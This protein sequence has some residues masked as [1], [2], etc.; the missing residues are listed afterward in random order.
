MPKSFRVY[1]N[2]LE[3]DYSIHT[4]PACSKCGYLNPDNAKFCQECGAPLASPLV[5]EQVSETPLAVETPAGRG[6]T[7]VEKGVLAGAILVIVLIIGV[8]ASLSYS[9]S[10]TAPAPPPPPP[11]P[12]YQPSWH[13]IASLSGGDTG[14]DGLLTPRFHIQNAEFRI[15]WN[16]ASYSGYENNCGFWFFV[17]NNSARVYQLLPQFCQQGRSMGN[18]MTEVSSGTGTFFLEIDAAWVNWDVSIMDYY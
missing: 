15:L 10:R 8:F 16:Y 4:L 12:A 9:P 14:I 2:K 17:F 7:G 13:S 1:S 18:S 11:P 5:T 6:M 3:V